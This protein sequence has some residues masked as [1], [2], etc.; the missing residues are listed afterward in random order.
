MG[1]LSVPWGHEN[2]D[3]SLPAHWKVE[4]VASASLRPAPEDWADRLAVALSQP[5]A[6]EPRRGRA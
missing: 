6:G 4:Q 2:L 5:A 1:D 3:F